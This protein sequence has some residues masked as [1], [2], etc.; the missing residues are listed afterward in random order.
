MSRKKRHYAF[1]TPAV[2]ERLRLNYPRIPVLHLARLM[3]IDNG[4]L[5]KYARRLGLTHVWNRKKPPRPESAE[6]VIR[7]MK[8]AQVRPSERRG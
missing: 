1:L 3:G 8:L 2:A 5:G 6:T 4:T 7:M